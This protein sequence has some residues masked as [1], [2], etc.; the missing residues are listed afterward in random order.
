MRVRW[1]RGGNSVSRG[2]NNSS[3]DGKTRNTNGERERERERDPES[4]I[5]EKKNLTKKR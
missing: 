2:W 5:P 3:R 1:G 4:K